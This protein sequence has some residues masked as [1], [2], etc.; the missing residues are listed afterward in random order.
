MHDFCSGPCI[1]ATTLLSFFFSADPGH[2][3]PHKVACAPGEDSDQPAQYNLSYHGT[4]WVNNDPKRLRQH[5]S[6]QTG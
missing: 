4:Q 3:I 6:D 1:F 2:T 5:V